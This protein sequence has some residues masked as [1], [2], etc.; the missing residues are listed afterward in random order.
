MEPPS[1]LPQGRGARAAGGGGTFA[2]LRTLQHVPG[3]GLPPWD[4]ESSGMDIRRR[5]GRRG[6][7]AAKPGAS[8]KSARPVP[9]HAPPSSLGDPDAHWTHIELQRA[10]ARG[11][12]RG[13]ASIGSQ[14]LQNNSYLDK[15]TSRISKSM[16]GDRR[17][18]SDDFGFSPTRLHLQLAPSA[19]RQAASVKRPLC[20]DPPHKPCL[21]TGKTKHRA[22]GA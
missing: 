4:S 21:L 17:T 2:H 8:S 19:L 6:R 12:P 9:I 20:F 18:H 15:N 22:E 5:Q 10:P 14:A 7:R 16:Q 11:T 3:L 13:A 1:T